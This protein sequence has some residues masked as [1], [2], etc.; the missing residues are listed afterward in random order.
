MPRKVTFATLLKLTEKVETRLKDLTNVE[1][2]IT[3]KQKATTIARV[4][5][6]VTKMKTLIETSENT[7]KTKDKTKKKLNNYILFSNDYRE[8]AKSEYNKREK[9]N[10]VN[11]P[12]TQVSSILSKL[13]KGKEGDEWRRKHGVVAKVSK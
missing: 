9:T 5:T 13:W 2:K 8:I 12:V 10:V 6:D 11:P 7:K 3:E 4:L 1:K